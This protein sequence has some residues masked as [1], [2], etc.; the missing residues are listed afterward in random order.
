MSTT[1]KLTIGV[2]VNLKNYE[3]LRVEVSDDVEGEDGGREL[4]RFLDQTLALFG[5]ESPETEELV[6]QYRRRVLGGLESALVPADETQ[7]SKAPAPAPSSHP[8]HAPE[9]RAHLAPGATHTPSQS[10]R[11]VPDAKAPPVPEVGEAVSYPP[12]PRVTPSGPSAAETPAAP[13]KPAS[14]GEAT[15]MAPTEKV[16]A[17]TTPATKPPSPGVSDAPTLEPSAGS[18]KE[19]TAAETPVP[20]PAAKAPVPS[21]TG[22]VCEGCGVPVTA[23]EERA[24]R[25][26]VSKTLCKRCIQKI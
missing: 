12:A 16:P 10:P 8:A 13:L 14:I 24:S 20:K 3:S 25:L 22:A 6:A 19:A 15:A 1:R 4:A 17:P 7:V 5:R 2:T 23:A 26:F 18:P 21:P 9:R 11:T